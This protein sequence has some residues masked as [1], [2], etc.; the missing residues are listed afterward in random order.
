LAKELSENT[1]VRSFRGSPKYWSPEMI[2]FKLDKTINITFKT[3]IWSIGIVIYELLTLKRPFKSDNEIL[4][5]D[6]PNLELNEVNEAILFKNLIYM[7]I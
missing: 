1:R 7:Y 2:E 5:L 4:S 6:T 3:D